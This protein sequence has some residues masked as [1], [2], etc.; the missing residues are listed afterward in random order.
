[1]A[2]TTYNGVSCPYAT[3]PGL[4]PGRFGF[5]ATATITD[6]G[7]FGISQINAGDMFVCFTEAASASVTVS[8]V[9]IL[10]GSGTVVSGITFTK[11]GSVTVGTITMEVWVSNFVAS[12]LTPVSSTYSWLARVNFSATSTVN[13]FHMH[14][15][16][17]ASSVGA[18][19][20]TGQSSNQTFWAVSTGTINVP[21]A[22]V[23]TG[24]ANS[25]GSTILGTGGLPGSIHAN[26]YQQTTSTHMKTFWGPI[27]GSGAIASVSGSLATVPYVAMT[28][29]INGPTVQLDDL[30]FLITE[31]G[32]LL[33]SPVN[34]LPIMDVAS[35]TGLEDSVV[36]NSISAIDGADGSYVDGKFLS[37]K[38]VVIE[39][40]I[41]ASVPVDEVIIDNLKL[42]T[43]PVS[44]PVP[45]FYKLPLYAPRI[46]M[47]K[48]I[49][50]NGDLTRLRSI[51][52][53][54]YQIQL[55][56]PDVRSYNQAIGAAVTSINYATL[57]AA[58]AVRVAVG[59][60]IATYPKIYFSV[61]S[62][63]DSGGTPAYFN[64]YNDQVATRGIGTTVPG[65]VIN[66][67][68]TT[69]LPVGTYCLDLGNRTLTKLGGYSAGGTFTADT[70]YSSAITQRQW[71]SL[72]PQVNNGI[73]MT[74]PSYNTNEGFYVVEADA[75]R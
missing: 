20:S 72:Q 58:Y 29:V 10:D 64:F 7:T 6:G 24:I 61:F 49:G 54:P 44:D 35:V 67:A 57:G 26:E 31:D 16:S 55:A 3:A 40:T 68:T 66:A 75:W 4:A 33:N 1:M 17:N 56:S 39:G 5:G 22:L 65:L 60:N 21:N 37:G 8:S 52:Q 74:R 9:Q 70:D 13:A 73:I 19:T 2:L 14:Q 63:G 41:T 45:M 36:T 59:G 23:L 18:V 71:F 48:P 25:N 50:L 28:I 62:T 42:A 43:A 12:K 51:G 34:A 47:V 32:P 46:L 69:I 38:T 11:K 30:T 27:N 15:I 53:I